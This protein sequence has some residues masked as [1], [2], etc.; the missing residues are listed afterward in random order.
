MEGGQAERQRRAAE[1]Q[2]LFRKVNE[3]VEGL[4]ETFEA[5]ELPYGT[6]TCECAHLDCVEHIDMTLE[7]YEALRAHPNQFAIMPAQ[8][9]FVLDVDALIE[10]TDRYWVVAMIGAGAA[11]AVELDRGAPA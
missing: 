4:N 2:S 9:H 3:R 1:N 8:S 6:W 11:L 10:R 7:E 5:L